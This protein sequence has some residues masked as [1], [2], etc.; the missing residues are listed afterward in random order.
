VFAAE[1]S[2]HKR[3]QRLEAGGV[4]QT[5]SEKLRDPRWQKKRLEIM[6]AAQFQCED[7]GSNDKTLHVHHCIYMKGCEPWEYSAAELICVCEDCHDIR[8]AYERDSHL[9]LARILRHCADGAQGFQSLRSVTSD[10]VQHCEAVLDPDG[11]TSTE[12]IIF[13]WRPDYDAGKVA[14]QIC[15]EMGI[16]WHDLIDRHVEQ[17][18]VKASSE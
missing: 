7:C 13:A 14:I 9:A 17:L 8:D 5:Y 3:R 6:E 11:T 2:R 4:K 15:K 1:G 16:S 18:E 10:L 12:D